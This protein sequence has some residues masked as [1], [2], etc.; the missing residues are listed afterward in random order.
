M[1]GSTKTRL[2]KHVSVFSEIKIIIMATV[3]GMVQIYCDDDDVDKNDTHHEHEDPHGD[4][5]DIDKDDAHHDHADHHGV[6]HDDHDVDNDDA[7]HDHADPHGE[8]HGD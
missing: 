2:Q 3:K 1:Y 6:G 5:H 8:D 7:H 4:G